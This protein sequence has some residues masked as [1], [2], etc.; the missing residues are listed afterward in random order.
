MIYNPYPLIDL[1]FGKDNKWFV[2]LFESI[3][4]VDK[5]FIEYNVIIKEGGTL[6]TA[7]TEAHLERVF[8]YELYRQW[9]N[10]LE[11]EGVRN[12]VVNGEI[13]KYLKSEF[14]RCQED[15]NKYGKDNYPDLVLHQ[16]QGNDFCQKMVC[17][18][19]RKDGIGSNGEGL[20]G[21]LFKLSCYTDQ[22]IFWKK[23]FDYGVF[24]LE[25]ANAKLIDLKI[26]PG[27]TTEFKNDRKSVED[28]IQNTDFKKKFKNIVCIAYDGT[29]LE[30]ETLDK[31]IDK[32]TKK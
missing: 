24:I 15:A 1:P 3:M 20:L 28:Y 25:G 8:A 32:I 29:N 16:S 10:L 17:E 30:Y 21:D 18:I 11:K 7:D 9:M 14:E 26:K 27:T 31:L 22:S 13:G 19:K 12:L 4:K 6:T 5:S 2:Y 23:E